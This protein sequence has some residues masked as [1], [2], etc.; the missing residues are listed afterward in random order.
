MSAGEEGHWYIRNSA[1]SVSCRLGLVVG[2][3]V[4]SKCNLLV[5]IG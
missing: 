1:V 3:A 4:V 2:D 5:E